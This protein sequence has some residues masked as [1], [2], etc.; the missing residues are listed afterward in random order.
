MEYMIVRSRGQGQ[1]VEYELL[2]DGEGKTGEEFTL[3][4]SFLEETGLQETEKIEM[5]SL[6]TWKE[7]FG[8]AKKA[9]RLESV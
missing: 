8:L 4:L 5:G 2:Y 6:H 7:I 9:E 3:G 1:L